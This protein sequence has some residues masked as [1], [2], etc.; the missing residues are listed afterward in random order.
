[1]Y[2]LDHVITFFMVPITKQEKILSFWLKFTMPNSVQKF[3]GV[4]EHENDLKTLF[5]SYIFYFKGF[6]REFPNYEEAQKSPWIHNLV[7]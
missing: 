7:I 3:F 1:M 4:L 2:P 6:G 5:L